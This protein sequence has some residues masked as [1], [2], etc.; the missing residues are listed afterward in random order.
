MKRTELDN[1]SPG[2]IPA[3]QPLVVSPL[4]VG[5]FG[6]S[7]LDASRLLNHE[8]LEPN[9]QEDESNVNVSGPKLVGKKF[10]SRLLSLRERMKF[11]S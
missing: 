8:T 1:R 7:P 2:W 5:L 9:T 4:E 11:V 10:N 6:F 3:T